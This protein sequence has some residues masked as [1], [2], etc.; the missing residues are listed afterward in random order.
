VKRAWSTRPRTVGSRG[1]R[2]SATRLIVLPPTGFVVAAGDT[3]IAASIAAAVKL[4]MHRT[5][6]RHEPGDCAGRSCAVEAR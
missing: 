1:M 6:P 3:L 2:R 4:A 5:T